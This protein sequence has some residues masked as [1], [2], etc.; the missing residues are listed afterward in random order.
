MARRPR[1]M[2]V[3]HMVFVKKGKGGGEG[4]KEIEGCG[5]KRT[6]LLPVIPEQET[7]LKKWTMRR[8]KRK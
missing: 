8:E 5:F 7:S 6:D 2:S 1:K 3:E 4:C